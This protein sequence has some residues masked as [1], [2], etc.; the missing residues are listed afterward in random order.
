LPRASGSLGISCGS[1]KRSGSAGAA[2][3]SIAPA[4]AFATL[5]CY[6]GTT[7]AE[8]W[9]ALRLLKALQAERRGF[10]RFTLTRQALR[11]AGLEDRT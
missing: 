5:L 11:P 9:R 1:A 10:R 7:L 2:G 3:I 6:R 8:L 4:C